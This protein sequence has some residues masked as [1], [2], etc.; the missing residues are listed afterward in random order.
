MSAPEIERITVKDEA[1]FKTVFKK[2]IK[3]DKGFSISLAAPTI[4]GIPDIYTIYP[5]YIPLLLEAKF[6]K[7]VTPKFSRKINY[8]PLQ[9]IWLNEC[10]KVNPFTAYGLMGFK[11]Q[12]EIWCCLTPFHVTQLDFMFASKFPHCLYNPKTKLFDVKYMFGH[13]SIPKLDFYNN[14]P[15]NL[16]KPDL[17][18]NVAV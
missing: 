11:W 15:A 1:A 14:Y 5:G 13:S 2:S 6:F 10:N 16:T 18:V 9:L 7:E 17:P 8:S 4:S 12:G 3:A